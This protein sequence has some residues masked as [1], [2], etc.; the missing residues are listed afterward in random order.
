MP[1]TPRRL[2]EFGIE[3]SRLSQDHIAVLN[4]HY[5]EKLG[6]LAC[7]C[8]EA[9]SKHRPRAVLLHKPTLR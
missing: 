3:I 7:S 8:R 5:A 4:E 9:G 2:G 1:N 6:T